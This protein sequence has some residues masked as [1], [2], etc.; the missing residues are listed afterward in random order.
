MIWLYLYLA[1][2]FG[3]AIGI[4]HKCVHDYLEGRS[5]TP[6]CEDPIP[7]TAGI[8]V[9]AIIW[10]L[11]LL[12]IMLFSLLGGTYEAMKKKDETD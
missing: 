12:E 4:Q 3:T 10:P 7:L 9:S 8:I 2:G 6:P 1:I 5:G 11:Q